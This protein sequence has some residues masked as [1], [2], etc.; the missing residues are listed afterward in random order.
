MPATYEWNKVSS[1]KFK[2]AFRDKDLSIKIKSF[3]EKKHDIQETGIDYACDMFEDIL[4]DAAK[5]CLMMKNSKTSKKKGING[6]MR[7]YI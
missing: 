4:L 7:I 2:N 1:E 3:M 6:M 5:R